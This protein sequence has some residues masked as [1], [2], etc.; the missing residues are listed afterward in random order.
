MCII[1][2]INNLLGGLELCVFLH[3]FMPCIFVFTE[4]LKMSFSENFKAA[5]KKLGL[6]QQA[7]GELLGIDRSA[8]AHYENGTSFPCMKNIAKVCET[9]GVT[10]ED[11]MK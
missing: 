1:A 3:G 10:I 7:L 11:L 6:T 8:I 2:C 5:R 4:D 9:L